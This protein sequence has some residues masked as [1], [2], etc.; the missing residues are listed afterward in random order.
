[1][2]E[3]MLGLPRDM[4]SPKKVRSQKNTSTRASRGTMCVRDSD[5][6]EETRI[7]AG[8]VVVVAIK[9]GYQTSKDQALLQSA[10]K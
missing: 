1:M 9:S 5:E 10:H 7:I 2:L 3:P 4:L 8:P 6:D